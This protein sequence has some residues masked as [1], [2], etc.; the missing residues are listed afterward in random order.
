M[1]REFNPSYAFVLIEQGP[2]ILITT[3]DDEEGDNVF[4]LTWSA[5][6][7]FDS[8]EHNIL[9][10]TGAWNHSYKTIEKTHRLTLNIPIY[11]QM[12]RAILCGSVSF[13]ECPDKF[14][15]FN[16]TNLPGH[17]NKAPIIKG[18]AG[19]IE[20]ELAK[21]YPQDSLLILNTLSVGLDTTNFRK[22]KIHAIGDGT[23]T[24]DG[25]IINGRDWMGDKVPDN[26]RNEEYEEFAKLP[27]V[28]R[29][30]DS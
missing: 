11:S 2:L 26:T 23:F 18:C 13:S 4:P 12:R 15:K 21:E 3:H 24:I 5:A 17:K 14:E 6:L 8:G 7:N 19:Y 28:S 1:Y 20:C 25:K 10:S 22:P 30:L 16:L 29:K 9:I 27:K